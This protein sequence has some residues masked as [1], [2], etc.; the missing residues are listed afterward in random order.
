MGPAQSTG[1]QAGRRS[2]LRPWH[3][4]PLLARLSGIIV[5]DRHAQHQAERPHRI[6]A[7]LGGDE[8]VATH[9]VGVCES[10]RLKQA[11]AMALFE[12]SNS[13]ACRRAR[14][15]NWR[16][17]A[18]VSGFRAVRRMAATGIWA[19]FCQWQMRLGSRLRARAV[20]WVERLGSSGFA[21]PGAG[22]RRG[23]PHRTC[24]VVR[25]WRVFHDEGQIL[26][27]V[28]SRFARPRQTTCK[29]YAAQ[30]SVF[31]FRACSRVSATASL[32]MP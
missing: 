8:A 1:W 22:L 7:A 31:I 25:F 19:A 5:A 14:A 10:L 16:S 27:P 28:L 2:R 9:G 29:D 30:D 4:G 15:R 26:H 23:R 3:H 17:S 18:A 12:I 6:V 21:R 24:G 11:L 20:A 32:E 13:C